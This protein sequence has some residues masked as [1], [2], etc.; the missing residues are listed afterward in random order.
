MLSFSGKVSLQF[1]F[2]NHRYSIN[3]LALTTIESKRLGG[4]NSLM[5]SDKTILFVIME[6]VAIEE[7]TVNYK[8]S[9]SRF[10]IRPNVLTLSSLSKL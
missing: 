3:I 4:S 9:Q 5:I 10:Q 1:N 7:E 6:G 2:N 8:Q